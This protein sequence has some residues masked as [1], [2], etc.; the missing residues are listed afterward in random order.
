MLLLIGAPEHRA[1]A[2]QEAPEVLIT[3]RVEHVHASRLFT[4]SDDDSE[5]ELLVFVPAAEATPL[6][7]TRVVARGIFGRCKD[8]ESADVNA[9]NELGDPAPADGDSRQLFIAGVLATATGHQLVSPNARGEGGALALAIRPGMLAYHIDTLAGQAVRVPYARV[10]GVF[11]P[12]VFLIDSQAQLAP[13]VGNRARVLVLIDGGKL[14]VAP[15]LLVGSTVTISGVARTLLGMQ[16]SR[17]VPWPAV[18]TRHEIEHLEIKAAILARS[19]KTPDGVELTDRS[20][21][22]SSRSPS[23]AVSPGRR[24]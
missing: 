11:E 6:P 5:R 22:A 18:L 13:L 3:G 23:P 16:V 8:A 10:I 15:A 2:G 9:C 12:N 14:R 24:Q 19:V 17:E 7:G 1:R 20:S 4:I 21:A